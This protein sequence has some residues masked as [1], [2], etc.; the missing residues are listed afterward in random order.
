MANLWTMDLRVA[1]AKALTSG[2]GGD[3]RPAWSPD[4]QWI[5]FSSDRGSTLPFAHGRWERLQLVDLYVIHP[6]GTGLNADHRARQL[7]R[8]SEVVGRQPARDRL[9]HDG[10]T[11]AGIAEPTP[12]AGQRHAPRFD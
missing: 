12:L 4:G 5:A 10:R 7:L 9:L 11:D 6:D 3:F 1:R 8:Q 2:A